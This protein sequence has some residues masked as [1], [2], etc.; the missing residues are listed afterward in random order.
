VLFGEVKYFIHGK[1]GSTAPITFNIHILFFP[2]VTVKLM[3]QI[4]FAC[5]VHNDMNGGA[6]FLCID[7]RGRQSSVSTVL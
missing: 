7:L 6:S 1:M 2:L 5:F 4:R 3:K